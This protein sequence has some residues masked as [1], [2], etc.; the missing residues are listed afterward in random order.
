MLNGLIKP[1]SGRIQIRGR[2]G[3]II[4]L[5]AGFNPILTGRENIYVN[6]AI[7]GLTKRETDNKIDKIIEFAEISEFIDSPVR[8]YSSGMAV[9]LGFAVATALRPDV[10]ILDEVLA[11][12][13]AAFRAK[14]FN[15][16]AEFQKEGT[17]FILVSHDLRTVAR[18]SQRAIYLK[19]GS[20]KYMGSTDEC[21]AQLLS[22]AEQNNDSGGDYKTDWSKTYGSGR[23][24]LVGARFLASDDNPTDTISAGDSLTFV[25]EYQQVAPVDSTILDIAIRD[26]DSI[27]YQE[28]KKFSENC[29]G[30][31]QQGGEFRIKFKTLPANVSCLDFSATLLDGHTAE[32]ID[33]KGNIPLQVKQSGSHHGS[34][35]LPT[36]WEAIPA[37]EVSISESEK[38]ANIS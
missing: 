7:M 30:K 9:R 6:A 36:E 26:G 14:C 32:I 11:V 31:N 8:S 33:W 27:V 3:A 37:A 20:I 28:T 4:A 16:L 12:G 29:L 1:D 13:D 10:L 24:K 25:I 18:L 35:I 17:A 15:T 5:G 2:V 23:I 19:G 34:L 21:V 22:D 38:Y